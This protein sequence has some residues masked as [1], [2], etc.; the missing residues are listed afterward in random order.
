MRSKLAISLS[1]LILLFSNNSQGQNCLENQ[2]APQKILDCVSYQLD[3][4]GNNDYD[5]ELLKSKLRSA[6]SAFAKAKKYNKRIKAITYLASIHEK[7]NE[8]LAATRYFNQTEQ[9]AK[10]KNFNQLEFWIQLK[11]VPLYRKT[12]DYSSAII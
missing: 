8:L 2:N 3:S 11:R 10:R 4:L 5:F 7:Q 9:L 12:G 6:V 1:L